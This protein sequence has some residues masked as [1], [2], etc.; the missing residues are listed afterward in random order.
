VLGDGSIRNE[1]NNVQPPEFCVTANWS[2][3][4]DSVW[5]WSDQ[6]CD[7]FHTFICKVA[8]SP[9][10]NPPPPPPSPGPPGPPVD[11]QYVSQIQRASYQFGVGRAR[12]V[13]AQAACKE[14]GGF[15]VTYPSLSK[16]VEI[17]GVFT[18]RGLLNKNLQV[19]A[20][21][22]WVTNMILLYWAAR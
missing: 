12:F 17:E 22:T 6:N 3:T 11:G 16:Q 20:T 19:R 9:P 4:Y 15:L 21:P 2:Q 7:E 14:L 18:A 5:G 1:P 10:P 8:A 13:D